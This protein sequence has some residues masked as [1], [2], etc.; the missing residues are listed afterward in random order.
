MRAGALRERLVIQAPVAVQDAVW[1]PVTEW[2]DVLAAWASVIPVAGS[3]TQKDQGVQATVKYE[4]EIR[5]QPGITGENRIVWNGKTLDI[6]SAIDPEGRKRKLLIQAVEQ[7][8]Q[9][10]TPPVDDPI[11]LEEQF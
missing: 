2:Q 7:V 9:N 1:G 6:E 11:V 3:E 10:V 8:G 4:I 5:Y